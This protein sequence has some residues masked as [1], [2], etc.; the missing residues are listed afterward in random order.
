MKSAFENVSDMNT[1]YSNEFGC[2]VSLV[3]GEKV[4]TEKG[5]ITLFNQVKNLDDEADELRDDGFNVLLEDPNSVSGRKEMFDAIGDLLVFAHGAGHMLGE[6]I[7][8]KSREDGLGEPLLGFEI[9][10]LRSPEGQIKIQALLEEA[11]EK[12]IPELTACLE[13]LS[14]IDADDKTFFNAFDV[15]LKGAIADFKDKVVARDFEGSLEAYDGINDLL[16]FLFN[17]KAK[18]DYTID[19]LIDRITKSNM[20][21]I[22]KNAEEVADTVAF[23]EAKGVEVYSKESPLFQEDGTPYLLVCSAKEQIVREFN[24]D[25]GEEEDKVYRANKVL[26]NIHWFEPNLLDF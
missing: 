13:M 23:Y 18:K 14:N 3:N 17:L 9:D 7:T 2:A 8:D 22:C 10:E 4:I 25:K 15:I 24:E 12:N 20:S 6:D 5:A 1:A 11:K 19:L 16:E 21:K 26:K